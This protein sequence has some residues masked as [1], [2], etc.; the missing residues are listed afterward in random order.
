MTSI[1][2]L[3]KKA[4]TLRNEMLI[5]VGSDLV[6]VIVNLDH[7]EAIPHEKR[8]AKERSGTGTIVAAIQ[9]REIEA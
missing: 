2:K 6:Q 8:K 5:G 1:E 9:Y 4:T 3:S 7:V